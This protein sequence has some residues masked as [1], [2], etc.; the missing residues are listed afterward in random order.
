MIWSMAVL[1]LVELRMR[2]GGDMVEYTFYEY[3]WPLF[4]IIIIIS[5][6]LLCIADSGNFYD[7]HNCYSTALKKYFVSSWAKYH[8]N[9]CHK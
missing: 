2:Y 6:L 4:S 5:W 9:L 1:C 7:L 3:Y 8:D